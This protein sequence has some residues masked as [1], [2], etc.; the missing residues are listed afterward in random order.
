MAQNRI[1]STP[2]L[3]RRLLG[4]LYMSRLWRARTERKALASQTGVY[5]GNFVFEVVPG[6]RPG[7]EWGINYKECGVVKFFHAQAAD[8]FTPYMCFIDFMMFPAMGITLEREGTI[9][10]GCTHCDFRFRT[11]DATA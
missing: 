6:D 4:K 9:A 11:P 3:L 8:E 7:I 1:D 2:L 10:Q 5:P